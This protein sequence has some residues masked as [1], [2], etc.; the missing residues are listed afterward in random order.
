MNACDRLADTCPSTLLH[1]L[2][3]ASRQRTLEAIKE[4]LN[5]L[6]DPLCKMAFL[7]VLAVLSKTDDR[8]LSELV[9]NVMLIAPPPPCLDIVWENEQLVC[10]TLDRYVKKWIKAYPNHAL[11]EQVVN[12]VICLLYTSPSPR[13]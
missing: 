13:D 1:A 7:K 3:G 4:V 8:E 9:S 2:K 5:N 11:M 12:N 6:N 10:S